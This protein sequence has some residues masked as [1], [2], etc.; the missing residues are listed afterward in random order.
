MSEDN[1]KEGASTEV[2]ATTSIDQQAGTV[3]PAAVEC[4][5]PPA[6]AM[7]ERVDVDPRARL[8]ELA[9]TLTRSKNRR[10]IVEYLRLRRAVA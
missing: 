1:G 3:T 8:L 10:L 7:P 5:S 9:A 6:A 2:V 4:E